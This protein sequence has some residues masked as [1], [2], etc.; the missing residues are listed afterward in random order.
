MLEHLKDIIFAIFSDKPIFG[1]MLFF[2]S[3]C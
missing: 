2:L 1:K 3:L